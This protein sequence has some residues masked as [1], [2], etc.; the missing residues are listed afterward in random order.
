VAL[1]DPGGILATPLTVIA[2]TTESRDIQAI[3]DIIKEYQPVLV[4]AGLPLSMDGQVREQANKVQA[5]LQNLAGAAGIPIEYRDERLSTKAARRSLREASHKKSDMK[6]RDD[7]AAAAVILQ[8][9]LDE[10]LP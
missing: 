2:R 1:S 9:Y 10:K 7:A 6:K 8:G 4:V 3:L 5:F